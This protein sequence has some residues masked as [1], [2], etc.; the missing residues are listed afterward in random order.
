MAKFLGGAWCSVLCLVCASSDAIRCWLSSI[1]GGP[2]QKKPD[3]PITN[4]GFSRLDCN[5]RSPCSFLCGNGYLTWVGLV[6]L[7]TSFL[8]AIPRR[9]GPCA[10][11]ACV[12]RLMER[13]VLAM[14]FSCTWTIFP[15]I[16]DRKMEMSISVVT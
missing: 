13:G 8:D 16:S 1:K 3:V 12:M 6:R 9:R 2:W 15:E 11:G 14:G 5:F 7:A 4:F 10:A